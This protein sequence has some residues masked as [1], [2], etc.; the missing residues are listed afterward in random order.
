MK[1]IQENKFLIKCN[2]TVYFKKEI[3]VTLIY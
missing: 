2:I 1:K 3:E